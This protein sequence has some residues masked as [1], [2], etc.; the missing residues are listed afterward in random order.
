[1][2]V[3]AAATKQDMKQDMKTTRRT[4]DRKRSRVRPFR[5]LLPVCP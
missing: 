2:A 4:P 3:E 5:R 1:V